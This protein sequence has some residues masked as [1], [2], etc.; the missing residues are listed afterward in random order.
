LPTIADA[1]LDR[2]AHTALRLTLRGDSVL[3]KA[4]PK[5]AA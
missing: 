1:I 4:T 5:T 2:I 3:E